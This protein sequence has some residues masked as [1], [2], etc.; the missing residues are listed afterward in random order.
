MSG[1]PASPVSEDH[2]TAFGYIIHHFARLE[3]LTQCVLGSGV[4][5]NLAVAVMLTVD[6]GYIQIY[7]DPVV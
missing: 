3:F 5:I 1:H 4:G 6:M 2:I 7:S